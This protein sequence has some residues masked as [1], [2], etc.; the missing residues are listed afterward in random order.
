MRGE[1]LLLGACHAHKY[2]LPH[3]IL[4]IAL[5]CEALFHFTDEETDAKV[6][7]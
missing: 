3:C 4:K 6:C 7:S 1:S 5:R 2:V